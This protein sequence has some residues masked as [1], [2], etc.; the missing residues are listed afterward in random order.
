MGTLKKITG[1]TFTLFL[2]GGL[3][4]A[5]GNK[6]EVAT[7]TNQEVV[8]QPTLEAE[9]VQEGNNVTITWNTNLTISAENY[10]GDHVDGE[11]HAHVYVD[12][13]KIAG[14]KSTDPYVVEGLTAGKHEIKIE[15]QQNNHDSYTVSEVFEV[16][17]SSEVGAV[18][19]LEAE[20][21]QEGNKVAITWN[22]NLAISADNY[23]A[24]HVDGEG[25]AHVYVDGEKIAG[26]KSTD[27]YVVEGLAAGKHVIEIALQQNDHVPY[28]VTESFEVEVN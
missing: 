8:E 27:P 17:V 10:G 26:L 7:T 18:P 22:T 15:L 24:D 20:F 25:H 21:A 11:G 12:G 23:G 1:I 14:L 4:T 3:M 16:E 6:E 5:C 19:T 13:E 2:V 28:E 9:F